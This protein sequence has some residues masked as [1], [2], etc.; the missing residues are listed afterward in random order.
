[1]VAIDWIIVG[2]YLLLAL[3]V[4]LALT[5]RASQSSEE[6]FVAGRSLP[7]WLAGTSMVATTFAADTPLAVTGLVAS[8][9][10][11]GNWIWWS[12]GIAHVVAA[13]V[14]A[15]YWRRLRV[16]TDAEILEQRYTG[17][18][19][20]ALRLVKA[21][22]QALFLNCLTMGWVI[23]A[24]R[25]VSASL[26]PDIDP[27]GVTF[28]LM[29]LAVFYSL[30]GG[31]RS[32]VITDMVQFGLALVG[33]VLL[34]YFVLDDPRIGGVS[35]LV[36]GLQKAY[37]D[38]SDAMLQFLP[39]GDLPGLPVT[40][41]A[42][43]MTVAWWRQAEGSGYIVQRLGATRDPVDAER[44]SIW[45]AVLHNAIRPWPWILVGLAALVFW[46]LGSV[47]PQGSCTALLSCPTGFSCVEQVCTF[48]REATYA[49]LLVEKLPP[50]ALGVMVVSLL[51]AFMSTIDTHVN[52]GSSYLVRDVWQ[53]FVR[54][55]DSP[56][57]LVRVGRVG[58][59]VM[60][61]V[62]ACASTLMHSIVEV[63]LFLITLGSGLGS[64]AVMRWLWW[65][66]NA[67]AEL[68]ALA[69][70]TVLSLGVVWGPD[71]LG[72]ELSRAAGIVIVALGSVA[73]W[74]PVALLTTP[75]VEGTLDGFYRIVRPLG[76]WG[77]VARR[78]PEVDTSVERGL[79]LRVVAG[80]WAVFG[81]LFG[82]G[83]WILISPAHS[84]V[85][86]SGLGA[87]GWLLWGR[88]RT[89]RES[90]PSVESSGA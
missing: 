68:V 22:Y 31:I 86:L 12:W 78:N 83:G 49:L 5:R 77:P 60:A 6:Y 36:E 75:V 80:L 74:V 61:L 81:T 27:L 58:V 25:K 3:G 2:A 21:G 19:A 29:A 63:W 52:W 18:T 59:V 51:A 71:L 42:V 66:V 17:R 85:F 41:F 8:G 35:G 82:L 4:G 65:R 23:L 87:F 43:L 44:A 13:L 26:F 70:S 38:R 39:R 11:A 56:R 47:D 15:R 7:W 20:A 73:T 62:A 14:F 69:S 84:L 50:G 9:G 45:F 55:D 37:P 46:P 48:D 67:Q 89:E 57:D 54:P 33:A 53:R 1:M 76:A 90:G 72:V 64:V 79:W 28:G 88:G 16:V 34:L 32:V 40:L 30:L 10:I 24:M